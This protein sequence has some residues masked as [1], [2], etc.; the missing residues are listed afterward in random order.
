MWSCLPVNPKSR[1]EQMLSKEELVHVDPDKIQVSK[2]C[3]EKPL[4]LK[5]WANFT[6]GSVLGSV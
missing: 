6:S 1:I 4:V 2:L 5:E 3:S